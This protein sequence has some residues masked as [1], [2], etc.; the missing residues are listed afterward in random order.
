MVWDA[1]PLFTCYSTFSFIPAVGQVREEGLE[2]EG[3]RKHEK[4]RPHRLQQ[5]QPSAPESQEQETQQHG[6][7]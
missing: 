1:K 6:L 7:E 2:R 5:N 4:A 3:A